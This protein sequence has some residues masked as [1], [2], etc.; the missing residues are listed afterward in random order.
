M[1]GS[2]PGGETGDGPYVIVPGAA[3]WVADQ[4]RLALP[5]HDRDC[6]DAIWRQARNGRNLLNT[7]QVEHL[8]QIGRR[9]GYERARRECAD[10]LRALGLRSVL[11]GP[12]GLF[13]ALDALAD[14]WSPTSRRA[15]PDALD[16]AP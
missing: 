14:R 7:V 3:E 5:G 12:S 6:A 4:E 2:V 11:G 16:G 10:E 15:G 9:A 8:L 13:A 1:T